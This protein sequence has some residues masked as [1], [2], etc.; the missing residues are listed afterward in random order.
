[1]RDQLRLL[2]EL[3]R[4][5]A[6]L[7]ELEAGLKNLPEKLQA[8]KN[9]LAKVEALL[10]KERASL[11]D[12]EKWRRDQELQLKTDEANIAKTKTKLQG[13]KTGKDYMAAQREMEASRKMISEREEEVLKL[14]EAIEVS[15]KSIAAHEQDVAQ[16]REHVGKEEAIINA[17][18]AELRG[19][20]DAERTQRDVIAAKVSPNVMKRYSTIRIRRGLA[21]VPV[22]NGTCMGCHMSIPPQLYNMLQRPNTTSIETCP[23]CNRIIYWDQIMV[24]KQ[25]ERGEEKTEEPPA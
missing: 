10:E 16:L 12:T 18:L 17:K 20:A 2:E 11:A 13:V 8:M 3:Q 19:R 6:R 9:D 15:K 25:L 22:V 23:Q 4:F 14:I 7:Q 1:M 5:D 21:V 24:D